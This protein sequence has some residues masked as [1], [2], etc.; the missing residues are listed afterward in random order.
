M[1]ALNTKERNSAILRFSLWLIVCVLIICIPVIFAVV[2]P[3][4]KDK[5]ELKATQA[6]LAKCQKEVALLNREIRF[7]KDTL[8]LQI[9]N[10]SE[11]L[12]KIKADMSN[13][14][15]YNME[16]LNVANNIEADTTGKA[17]W[18]GEMYKNISDIF[19]SLSKANKII[20][21]DDA[22]YSIDKSKFDAVVIEFQSISEDVTNQL[23]FKSAKTL[24]EAIVRIDKELKKAMKKLEA[25]K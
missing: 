8:A 4:N 16:L 12:D 9:R 13:V 10:I 23:P 17:K 14:D 19:K 2:F 18:R 15:T 1:K 25:L 20:V 5:E 24:H 11:I 6:E 3:A 21:R 7:D 22:K